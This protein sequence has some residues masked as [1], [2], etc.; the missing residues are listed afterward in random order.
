MFNINKWNSTLSGASNL[1]FLFYL[2]YIFLQSDIFI[3]DGGV[4]VRNIA[5]TNPE[6]PVIELGPEFEK[7]K[8][9]L[10]AISMPLSVAICL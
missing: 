6:D 7:V 5:R 9:C 2:I 3:C 8:I 10:T 1:L 4:L